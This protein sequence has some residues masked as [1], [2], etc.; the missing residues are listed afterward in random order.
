MFDAENKR[1]VVES[2]VSKAKAFA[3]NTYRQIMKGDVD[4]AELAISK[5][6]RKDLNAYKSM[7]PHVVVARH[8]AWQGK[9]LEEYETVDFVFTNAK[10]G[11]PLQRVIPAI[12]MGN[13]CSYYDREKYGKLVLDVADTILKPLK[14]QSNSFQNSSLLKCFM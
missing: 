7:F 2:Q 9:R 1:G 12:M 4:P 5:R 13:G 8:L 10:H 6:I 14:K 3:R 11:N